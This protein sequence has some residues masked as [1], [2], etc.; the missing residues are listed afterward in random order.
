[1][2]QSEENDPRKDGDRQGDERRPGEVGHAGSGRSGGQDMHKE[3]VD[4]PCHSPRECAGGKRLPE[5][6]LPVDL[7]LRLTEQHDQVVRDDVNIADD[8]A[9]RRAFDV[10]RRDAAKREVTDDLKGG[11]DSQRFQ[12]D[13]CPADRLQHVGDRGRDGKQ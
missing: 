10:D 3:V 13:V 11:T 1:M 9:D 6:A 4:G 5:D 12:R 8:G 2:D 7:D